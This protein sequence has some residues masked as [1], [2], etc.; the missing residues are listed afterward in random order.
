MN[1]EERVFCNSCKT[2]TNHSVVAEYKI[3]DEVVFFENNIEERIELGMFLYQVIECDGCGTI[4]FRNRNYR[5]EYLV[6]D[7][8][9]QKEVFVAGR[10]FDT[11]YPEKANNV[12]FAKQ[13]PGIPS[14]IFNV[15][16][17]IINAY[18]H[19]SHILCAAGL[20]TITEATCNHFKMD[21]DCLGA[22]IYNLGK[23]RL[24]NKELAES[25][26]AQKFLGNDAL[27][28]LISPSKEEL[29]LAVELLED[30]LNSLFTVP[31]KHNELKGR[32][33]KRM[34]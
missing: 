10:F 20:R 11:Y 30:V 31:F 13:F 21:G 8:I 3:P 34:E 28:N 24:I 6:Y 5:A 33:S 22:R 1:S 32:I 27:H 19:N 12:L 23:H 17:E 2:K 4:S 16:N 26:R 25:L 9:I 15:Y 7:E 18:N 14:S 29:K